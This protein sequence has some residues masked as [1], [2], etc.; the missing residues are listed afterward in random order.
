MRTRFRG[1]VVCE[2]RHGSWFTAEADAVLTDF[3]VARA[4][5]DPPVAGATV[6]AGGWQGLRYFRLHG[7]PR[8]YYSGYG[9][10]Y[11]QRLARQLD[12]QSAGAPSW[13]IFDNTAL[14]AATV[15]AV[16]LQE[17]TGKI[18]QT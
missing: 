10:A 3:Q 4:A 6:D 8:V 7:S 13:C 14:G 16:V 5:A 17:L 2:P 12:C 1:S 15:D 9:T 11:L 18:S